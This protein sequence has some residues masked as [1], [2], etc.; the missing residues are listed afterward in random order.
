MKC[1]PLIYIFPQWK[2]DQ[3]VSAPV[4][5]LKAVWKPH[6]ALDVAGVSRHRSS[7][8]ILSIAFK[9][10]AAS[11]LPNFLF[12]NPFLKG[13]LILDIQ[14][15]SSHTYVMLLKKCPYLWFYLI[16]AAPLGMDRINI[17]IFLLPPSHP[18]PPILFFQMGKRK[19]SD[20]EI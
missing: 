15:L 12:I 2:Q 4:C 7:Y 13:S 3:Y 5:F 8:V 16:F 17:V 14:M 19:F 6:C 20:D 11:S 18:H 1:P 10:L 9:K